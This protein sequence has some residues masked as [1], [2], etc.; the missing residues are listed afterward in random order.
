MVRMGQMFFNFSAISET[1]PWPEPMSEYSQ[2][3][4]F[5]LYKKNQYLFNR[6]N[7]SMFTSK[8]IKGLAVGLVR[9]YPLITPLQ[10]Q[11]GSVREQSFQL[12]LE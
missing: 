8:Q 6:S 7:S 1:R 10:I 11:V 12:L 9:R 3:Y 5:V 2:V 4:N